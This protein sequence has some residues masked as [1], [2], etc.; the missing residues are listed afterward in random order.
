MQVKWLR[1]VLDEGVLAI[2]VKCGTCLATDSDCAKLE[3]GYLHDET[4]QLSD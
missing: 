1:V 3:C 2:D 4:A